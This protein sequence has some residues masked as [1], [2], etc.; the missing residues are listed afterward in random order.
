MKINCTKCGELL[1]FDPSNFSHQEGAKGNLRKI[2][3][4]CA[5]KEYR[6]WYK[7]HKSKNFYE[8]DPIEFKAIRS[9]FKLTQKQFAVIIGV[10]EKAIQRYE[11]GVIKRMSEKVYNEYSKLK[12]SIEEL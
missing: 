4:V 8:Y 7:E 5:Y 3:K 1:E 9:H 2:C 11:K 10:S 6:K 12:E